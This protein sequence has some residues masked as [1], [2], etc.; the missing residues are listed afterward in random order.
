MRNLPMTMEVLGAT[1]H[2]GYKE[3]LELSSCPELPI[4]SS[5]D[6]VLIEIAHTDVNPLD[7]QKL[8]GN[9]GGSRTS[10]RC[11]RRD[12]RSRILGG[13]GIVL[14]TGCSRTPCE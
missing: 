14:E 9:N 4:I 5:E 12:I 10:R 3:S 11:Q 8:H 13:S 7:L 6:D 2:G 1:K